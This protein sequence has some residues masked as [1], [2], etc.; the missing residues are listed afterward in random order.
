MIHLNENLP[1]NHNAV[2]K[3]TAETIFVSTT[4]FNGTKNICF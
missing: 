1:S 4:C 2:F 3:L